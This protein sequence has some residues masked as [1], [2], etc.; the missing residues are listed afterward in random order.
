MALD[1]SWS[2][3]VRT[4]GVTDMESDYLLLWWNY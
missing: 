3:D 1:G 2:Q 4:I